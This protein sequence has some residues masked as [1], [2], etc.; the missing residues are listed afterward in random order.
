M[1]T[2]RRLYE[3]IHALTCRLYRRLRYIRDTNAGDAENA[4]DAEDVEALMDRLDAFKDEVEAR[5]DVDD[6]YEEVTLAVRC[7]VSWE[8]DSLD[9]PTIAT[10]VM[11]AEDIAD[12]CQKVWAEFPKAR[13]RTVKFDLVTTV[14]EPV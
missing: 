6:C 5:L 2:P 12:A 8:V 7:E 1:P 9:Y 10:T 14:G 11:D 4:D 13:I 3:G